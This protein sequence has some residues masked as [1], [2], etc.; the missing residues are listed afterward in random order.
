MKLETDSE[1]I[2]INAERAGDLPAQIVQWI[3]RDRDMV[4]V[5]IQNIES[6]LFVLT[7]IHSGEGSTTVNSLSGIHF[8]TH[9]EP[10][11]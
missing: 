7:H 3:N 9:S 10:Q 2:D 1:W 4:F 11:G 8:S 6:Y 5:L